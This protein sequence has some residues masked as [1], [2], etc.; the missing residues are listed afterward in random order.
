MII[1]ICACI[2]QNDV[3]SMFIKIDFRVRQG[4]VLSPYLFAVYVDD[5]VTR[6]H[7]A[8]YNIIST[9]PF[10]DMDTA[11]RRQS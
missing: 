11:S 2:K 3:T 5:M 1:V 9:V 10:M 6:L 8:M 7:A 4:S